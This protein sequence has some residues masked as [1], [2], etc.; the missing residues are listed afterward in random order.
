MTRQIFLD[1]ET[2]GLSP[3]QGGGGH[4][5]V[6][7]AC[8]ETIS[9]ALSGAVFHEY[10]NPARV[11]GADA[12]AI[13]GLTNAFLS[14]KPFFGDVAERFL[15][16]VRGAEVVI[17]NAPFDLLFINHE[18]A[19]LDAERGTHYGRIED[20]AASIVCSL[21]LA[22]KKHPGQKNN[23]DAL[24]ARYKVNNTRQ[25]RHGARV[26]AE[27]LAHVYFAMTRAQGGLALD[28]A[29]VCEVADTRPVAPHAPL[30]VI[31]ADESELA[32]HVEAMSDVMCAAGHVVWSIGDMG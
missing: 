14:N 9:R 16:F 1:T 8:V 24:C 2:T 25:D 17:H 15:A 30:R 3:H 4:R 20:H 28:V 5:L 18:L 21:K 7:L 29:P 12:I 10:L 22:R 26:D 6:E 19:R 31:K 27:T 11:V 23:L 32:R 13:H